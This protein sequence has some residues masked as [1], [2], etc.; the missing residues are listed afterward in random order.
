MKSSVSLFALINSVLCASIYAAPPAPAPIVDPPEL[1]ALRDAYSASIAPT[2]AKMEESIK[3]RSAQYAADLQKVEEQ[4]VATNRIDAIP[5]L[6]AEREAFA[7]GNW[8]TGFPKDDKRVPSTA[9]ELRYAYDRDTAKI[10]GDIVPAAR[11]LLNDYL[12][13]LDELERQFTN[14]KA[15]DGVLAVRREKE[16]LQGAGADPLGGSNSLIVGAWL[17]EKGKTVE[18]LPTGK[19]DGGKWFWTDR[20]RRAL[21]VNWN[22]GPKF[23]LNLVISPDGSEMS[24]VNASGEKRNFRR[25][26]RQPK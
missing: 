23:Y 26:P 10:R 17:D 7:A 19:L 13:K 24:G 1:I 2:R 8:T 6:R 5:L 14:A 18:F 3:V 16:S 11:P 21:R 20:A 12:R 25:K 15:V 22:V 9:R 4:A